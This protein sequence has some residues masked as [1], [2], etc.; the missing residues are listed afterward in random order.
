MSLVGNQKS[1]SKKKKKNVKNNDE[2]SELELRNPV[3]T[4]KAGTKT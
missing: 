1:D 4:F 2:K 3:A